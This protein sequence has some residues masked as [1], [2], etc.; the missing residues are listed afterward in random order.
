MPKTKDKNTTQFYINV[1]GIVRELLKNDILFTTESASKESLR[2]IRDSLG[3]SQRQANRYLKAARE[4]I[5][6]VSRTEVKEA[7][8]QALRDR[9]FIV[10]QAK[11]ENDL[12]MALEAMKDRDKLKGLYVENIKSEMT[13]KNIDLSKFTEHGLE[14]LK[15]GDKIEEVLID[16]RA[17][18]VDNV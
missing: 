4:E 14:R 10:L 13:I 3:V 8:D 7:L 6:K 12:K 5:L 18:K 11:K 17:V 2:L 1:N 16:P 15:R 9:H